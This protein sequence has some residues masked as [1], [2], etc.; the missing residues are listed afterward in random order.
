MMAILSMLMF[1][2][3]SATVDAHTRVY[4]VVKDIQSEEFFV[5]RAPII[6]CYGLARGPQLA[7]FTSEYNAN[8]NV[9]CGATPS[10]QNI[11]YLTC[12]RVVSAQESPDYMSFSEI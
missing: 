12:A 6:G 10:Q 2:T 9:G 5:E 7:Q 3:A 11:N 1:S 4:I 8:A